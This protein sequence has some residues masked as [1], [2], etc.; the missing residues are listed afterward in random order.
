MKI[1]SSAKEFKTEFKTKTDLIV[2][3]VI[4]S[5]IQEKYK[6]FD[7]L[8]SENIYIQNFGVSR[9]TVREAFK[10]LSSM[11]VVSIRQG[12]GTF[13]NEI[14][15]FE[16][17]SAL[18]PFLTANRQMICDVY[19]TRIVIEESIVEL[20]MQRKSGSDILRLRGIIE[21]MDYAI[22]NSNIEEYS[23]FDNAFH[24]TLTELCGN[25]VLISICESLTSVRKSNIQKSNSSIPSIEISNRE[26][27]EILRA[28]ENDDASS[29][30]ALIRKHLLYSKKMMLASIGEDA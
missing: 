25:P 26:H 2:E 16:I 28:I 4:N 5:I 14:K 13:V 24:D 29:A 22:E 3:S 15:P 10:R 1:M 18:L 20:V 21:K 8:P 6:P 9:V 30:K 27:R 11:G 12:D 19:E 23:D 17:K 7:K